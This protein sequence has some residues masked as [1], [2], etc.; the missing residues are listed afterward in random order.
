[1][2]VYRIKRNPREQAP[3]KPASSP[4]A[5]SPSAP[6]QEPGISR[7]RNRSLDAYVGSGKKARRSREQVGGIIDAVYNRHETASEAPATPA[8]DTD[9]LLQ[10]VFGDDKLAKKQRKL[11]AKQEK[12]RQKQLAKQRKRDQRAGLSGED[13]YAD[14][15]DDVDQDDAVERFYSAEE[16]SLSLAKLSLQKQQEAEAKAGGLD[17]AFLQSLVEES[18]R[19]LAQAKEAVQEPVLEESVCEEPA[20]EP[21]L[22][23]SACQEPAADPVL[24]ETAGEEPVAEPLAQEP[25]Q[26]Q[27]SPES[28]QAP[29][30][31]DTLTPELGE[32]MAATREFDMSGLD[33]ETVKSILE[34]EALEG[35]TVARD[36]ISEQDLFN[37]DLEEETFLPET[38]P[39]SQE[40][41]QSELAE[42]MTE[43]IKDK[44]AK[45][46]VSCIWGVLITLVSLY[47]ASACFTTIPHP[48]FLMPGKYGLVLIL[49]DL[50]LLVL[51]G[52]LIWQS[53]RD[54]FVALFT[55]KANADSI[56]A[57]L[58]AVL[59]V[60][61]ASLL[62]T[63]AT[64]KNVMLF[65]AVGCLFAAM[66]SLYH[67]LDE[68]RSYRSF[69]V[70]SS[71]KD[72]FVARRLGTDSS[73]YEALKEFIPEDPDIFTVER[74]KFVNNYFAR[75]KA[76]SQICTAYNV[77]LWLVLVV[78]VAAAVFQASAGVA[79][80]LKTFALVCLFGLPA[81]GLF[82][83]A[84]P[85]GRMAKKCA[86]H[87]SAVVGMSAV[88]EYCAPSVLS[89]ND[90]ELFP[91]E[92]IRLTSIR[93]YSDH[94]IDK[95]ILY[96]AM[97]FKKV[98]G[99]LSSVF[100]DSISG[101]YGQIGQDFDI[102]E[103]TGDGICAKIDGKEV[104]VGNKDYMLSYDF[105][106]VN[107]EIDEPFESSV[108]RIMYL[109]VTDTIAAKFY[110]RYAV[111]GKFERVMRAL[112][113]NGTCVSI[114]TCD[115]NLDNELIQCIMKNRNYPVGVLKTAGASMDRPPMETS[116]SGIVCTS[117][118]LNMLRAFIC[119]EK[120]KR[121]VSI[122]LLVKFISVFVGL[123]VAV[124]LTMMGRLSGV[125][126][127]FVLVYQLLWVLA[128]VVPSMTE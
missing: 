75:N 8:N 115:P 76:P 128:V 99:P 116:D 24:E 83:V 97:I 15:L 69:R 40:Y 1:M 27:A 18:D 29:L 61:Q 17:P 26:E 98:G 87:E 7:N 20:A 89:F 78:A 110:I 44:S 31:E 113:R 46:L 49:V 62:F 60:Y 59:G 95:S 72:K 39:C 71:P 109:A 105:G 54:G 33:T 32:D 81:C 23:E 88:E 70:I 106:Y 47:L 93:T 107:D 50:Q 28:E 91:P 111:N 100:A 74:A 119:C 52:V 65:S 64:D 10:E 16:L 123:F 51:S 55:L 77:V 80:S 118:I 114:K 53:L 92:K 94:R 96:A 85:L 56:T 22:E 112:H 38:K 36:A 90:T 37:D 120:A 84:L 41:T 82:G 117:S 45:M 21:V 66:N 104:F 19:E 63:S 9:R 5:V 73:E 58:L 43:G 121:L 68:R 101:V 48:A 124:L 2:A 125:T 102:L 122:N 4:A 35:L 86:A 30:Q 25:S 108:G 14:S 67:F 42:E 12:A 126:T 79:Q 6:S 34:K 103:N 3:E 57:V 11:E 127:A 13:P